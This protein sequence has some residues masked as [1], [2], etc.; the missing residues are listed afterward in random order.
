MQYLAMPVTQHSTA[1]HIA[2]NVCGSP[3]FKDFNGRTNVMCVDCYSVERTRCLQLVLFERDLVRPGARVLHLAPELGIARNILAVRDVIY[4]P[5]DFDPQRYHYRDLNVARLDLTIDAERLPSASYDLV[6]HNHVMEHI[7]CNITAVLF[8]LHRALKPSGA[9]VFSIPI[10]SGHYAEDLSNLPGQQRTE[11]FGQDD[12]VRR[13]GREDIHMTLG[14]VFRLPNDHDLERD[15]GAEVLTR[16][17]IPPFAWKGLTS[18]TIFTF[19]KD[20]MLLR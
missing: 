6:I 13:I 10:M 7:P 5:C 16:A 9:H 11:R 8:H 4:E 1:T 15:F 12:H 19:G 17:N 20:D 18:H 2:C 3:R 14:K